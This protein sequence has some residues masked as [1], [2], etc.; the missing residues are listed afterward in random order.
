MIKSKKYGPTEQH[1]FFKETRPGD[2]SICESYKVFT[3]SQQ[4]LSFTYKVLSLTLVNFNKKSR[5]PKVM[6]DLDFVL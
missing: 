2:R 1:R 4:T 3:F 5:K 6:V